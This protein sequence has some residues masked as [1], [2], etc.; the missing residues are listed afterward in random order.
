M[1][2]IFFVGIMGLMGLEGVAEINHQG[3]AAH[4]V[5][6]VGHMQLHPLI[7][8]PMERAAP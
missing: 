7:P 2:L 3:G 1:G 6:P 5:F 4:M 8:A